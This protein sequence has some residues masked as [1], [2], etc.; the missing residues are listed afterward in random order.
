MGGLIRPW[1]CFSS[2]PKILGILLGCFFTF[3]LCGRAQSA[4][5]EQLL[6][7]WKK[8]TQF[9]KILQDM[10]QGYKV[11]YKGYTTVK[12]ISQGSFDLHKNYLD[13]LLEVSPAVKNYKR[14]ADII[15]LQLRIIKEYK[16]A[17]NQFREDGM[18][19]P[20]EIDY[21]SK[22][23][24]NLLKRSLQS[25]DD[26]LMVITSG[27]LRMSDDERLQ[28]I[29]KIYDDIT[30]QFSFLKDFN[31]GTAVLSLQRKSEKA[32]IDLSRILSK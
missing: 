5:A 23:Y 3:S 12:D 7:D 32:D 10:Y 1:R 26:L 2:K 22:V 21:I 19:V 30:D 4:E 13:A 9:K 8:L 16:S 11:L 24:S 20:S 14:I 29:D 6:L 25:I 28:A 18:F 27:T 15:S 17:F 31:S